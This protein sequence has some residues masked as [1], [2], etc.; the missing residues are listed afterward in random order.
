MYFS[1]GTKF[2][3]ASDCTRTAATPAASGAAVGAGAPDS[4]EV[5]WLSSGG[6]ADCK[7]APTSRNRFPQVHL[8]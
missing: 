8:G 4:V 2:H 7:I 1:I 5:C 6:S 3:R